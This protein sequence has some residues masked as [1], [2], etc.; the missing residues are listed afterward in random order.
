MLKLARNFIAAIGQFLDPDG[1]TISW[2]YI[3]LL[4]E[5]QEKEGLKFANKLSKGHVGFHRHKMNVKI[6]AQTLSSSVADAI[7][8]LMDTGHS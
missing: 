3:E 2:K 6:A 1:N 4:H 8:F 7:Q 5:M